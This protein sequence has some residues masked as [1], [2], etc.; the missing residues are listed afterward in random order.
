MPV[1]RLPLVWILLHGTAIVFLLLNLATGLRIATLTHPWLLSVSALLPQGKMHELHYIG[2]VGLSALAIGF[3]LYTLQVKT[4]S[5]RKTYHRIVIWCGY[6]LLVSA[7]ASG[8]LML[9]DKSHWLPSTQWHFYTALGLAAYFVL[10]AGGYFIDWG[11]PAIRR[12]LQPA[13]QYQP[14]LMISLLL[15]VIAG[16]FSY[17]RFAYQPATPLKITP[18]AIDSF[19]IVDGKA[20]EPAW[21]K[22]TPITIMTRGGANFSNGETPVTLK[23]IE[24]GVEVF[25]HLRWQDAT[26][27]R[28][29]LPLM[30]TANGWKVQQDGFTRFDEVTHYEDKFAVM[31]SMNCEPGG[32]GTAHLGPKPLPNYPANWHGKGYHYSDDGQVRDIWHWKAVRTNDMHL[33]DDN[34]FASP[35]PP[36]AGERRYTAGY[37]PDGKESGAYV[38]NWQWYK[39]DTIVPKRLPKEPELLE[40]Y[41]TTNDSLTWVISWFDYEPYQAAKDHYPVGTI[42]PSV[43]YRSN[44][45]EGDRADVRA[46]G[47]WKDGWWSLE[48]SRRLDTGSPHDVPIQSRTCL[49]VSAFDSSQIAHTRHQQAIKLQLEPG[50]D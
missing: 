3:C 11:W 13:L 31:L 17:L 35:I 36:R 27:S 28:K 45:F 21:D 20:D 15:V 34:F 5:K 22:A 7:I 16:T 1:A 4:Q 2:G 48:M 37:L 47:Q 32:S 38:M 46:R 9:L 44:R 23:A 10:H 24:N 26:E 12:I 19:I 25:F 8:W 29:H 49:W 33:A 6:L 41:Q 42:M 40:P 50:N 14:L 39:P 30:K 18:I 43:M